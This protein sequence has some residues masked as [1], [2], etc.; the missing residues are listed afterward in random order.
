MAAYETTAI[1]DKIMEF[2]EGLISEDALV[3]YLTEEVRYVE[4]D[5]DV[6]VG[7]S[8]RA[9]WVDGGTPYT[10]GGWDEVELAEDMGLLSSKVM[11]RVSDI[12]AT[13]ARA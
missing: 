12:L 13:R 8:D 6:P 4:P 3:H 10:P 11:D 5:H 1:T 2:R 9:A 7:H